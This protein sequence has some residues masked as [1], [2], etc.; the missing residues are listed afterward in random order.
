[1]TD[2]SLLDYDLPREQIAQQPVGPRDHARLLILDRAR[3]LFEELRFGELAARL[4]PDDLL[5]VNDTRVLRA[6]LR[7]HKASG[8]RV[9]AL[10]LE[11]SGVAGW[12]AML[13]ATGRLRVG[14][15]LVFGG[16][17]EWCARLVELE[18]A[19][20]CV[21]EFTARQEP[22]RPVELVPDDIGEMPLPPYIQREAARKNDL[23]D[24][25]SVF[26]REPGAVAAPTASLHF[27]PELA[28][29]LPI[30]ALTLHVGPGTFRPLRSERVE[31]HVI[32]GERYDVPPETAAAIART[33]QRGGR[34]IAVGTTVVRAL[35]TSGGRAGPGTSEL[36]ITPGHAFR[37][38]DSIV[39]NFHLPR[40]TLLTLVMAF[41]GVEPVRRAYAHAVARGFRFYSYGDAMWLI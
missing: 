34:V 22:A 21:L 23:E 30:V 25:Q 35:E 27:T 19:G 24:Y 5:V 6:R 29:R 33:K 11:R 3:A 16:A 1:M 36:L 38:V 13:R 12:R 41:G 28:A 15:E 39:T 20:T 31:D 37:V 8:G 17:P 14:L 2:S 40:S 10:L 7:G 4:G 26:A 32:E 9:E 18:P